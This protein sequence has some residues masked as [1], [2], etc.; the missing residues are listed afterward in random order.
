MVSQIVEKTKS[1][2]S[3]T[4]PGD[5]ATLNA[6]CPKCND[7][8]K[9]NYKRY[10]CVACD[11]SISETPGGRCLSFTVAEI[12]IKEKDKS[13]KEEEK[14]DSSECEKYFLSKKLIIF[15]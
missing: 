11:F 15:K 4:I 10:G 13:T 2:D 12:F 5:Y 7:T 1:Y 9:E 3:I 8:V 14:V 6:P